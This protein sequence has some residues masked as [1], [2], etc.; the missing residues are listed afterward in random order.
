MDWNSLKIVL[1]IA[2]S[3]T[4]SGAAKSLG[5]NHSTVFRRLNAFEA[6]VGGRLFERFKYGYQLTPMGEELLSA[7]Q[8]ISEAFDDL[9]RQ[10]VGKDIQPKGVVKITAP[11]NIAYR[12]LPRYLAAFHAQYPDIRV[13]VLASNLEFNMSTRQADIAIRV[14]PSPPDYLVGRQLGSISWSVYASCDFQTKHGVLCSV[15]DLQH[16]RLIGA[17]GGMR[18]LPGFVWLE[19][20]YPE[21]IVTRC[22]DLVAMSYFAESGAGLAFLPDDQ[23]R[24][25]IRRL[26]RFEPG[27]TSCLWLLTHPDLRNVERIKLVMRHLTLAFNDETFTE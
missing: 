10:I 27:E 21:Q 9:E 16:H 15:D 3:G 7:A 4:L 2:E 1:A 5:I 11:N 13:E 25:E 23:L 19:Q 26:F 14:T 6:E 18:D 12:Y 22:D 20:H 8:N 24:P 17:A